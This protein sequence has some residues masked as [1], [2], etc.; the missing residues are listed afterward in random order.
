MTKKQ[1]LF[2]EESLS[3]VLKGA[4]TLVDAMKITL[5]PKSKSILIG[6]KW[7]VPIICNDGV[8]IARE[9]ELADP[10]ENLGAQMMREVAQKT[11]DA[12]GDGTTTATLIAHS[13]FSEGL[14]NVAAGASAI[15]LKKGLNQGLAAA[16]V[17]LH[18]LSRPIKGPLEMAQVATISA[19]NDSVLGKLVADAIHR[20][21]NEGAVTVEESQGTE[22][23]VDVV[24]GLKFDRGY[25]S[26]YFITDP[27]KMEATLDDP[28]I[29]LY[30]KKIS[31]VNDIVPILEQITKANRSILIIAEDVD[32]EALATLVVNKVRGVLLS[33]AVKAPGFG[34]HRK[35]QM[36]DMAIL[37]GGKFISEELGEKLDSLTLE[38]FGRAKKVR[39]TKDFTTIIGGAGMKM[40]LQE[41][42]KLLR[43]E[44]EQTSS[45]YEREKLR[46]RIA[47]LAGGVAVIH[48]GAPTETEIKIKKE[49]LDD[50]ISAT[51]AAAQEGIVAGGGLVFVRLSQELEHEEALATGDVKTGIGLLRRALEVPARQIAKNSNADDGVVVAEMKK[52]KGNFGFDGASGKFIDLV[53]AGIIDPTKV[54]RTALENAV[55]VASTLLLSEGTL[56]EIA[57]SEHEQREREA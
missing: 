29:L 31:H 5:G 27:E 17:K 9:I 43:T 22:T 41:R 1:I 12:V 52:N 37:C 51:R 7:G 38:H 36:Q 35:A 23:T 16:L 6:K 40:A 8:T 15:D 57:E 28:Y 50:S 18:E 46:E 13:I 10:V 56:T 24:E 54:V 44:L 47:K 21:G 19:H 3:K 39:S 30:E 25:L 14:R 34:D 45:T 26:S 48:V 49:A 42:I 20:V 11:G 32:G 4:T 53:A 55:S 33:L 2:K